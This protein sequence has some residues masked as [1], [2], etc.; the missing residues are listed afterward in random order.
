M[1]AARPDIK[2]SGKTSAEHYP[3][4]EDSYL[5]KLYNS[6]YLTP[7]TPTGLLNRVQMNIRL[8]SCRRA[9]ENMQ[10]MTKDII[11]IK[12]YPDGQKYIC[13]EVDQLTN[14]S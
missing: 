13:K 6:V 8:Y 1:K 5:K 4:I 14:K 10:S 12:I 2:R 11:K 9:N 3:K 7:N